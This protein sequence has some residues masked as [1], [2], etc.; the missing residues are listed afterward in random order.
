M[1]QISCDCITSDIS[2]HFPSPPN[3]LLYRGSI[4]GRNW[5]QIFFFS[6]YL[7]DLKAVLHF[8]VFIWVEKKYYNMN[9]L[10]ALRD[11]LGSLSRPASIFRFKSPIRESRNF[12]SDMPD[13][14]GIAA[15]ILRRPGLNLK[16]F[17][18]CYSQS[19]PPADLPPPP[20]HPMVV[21]DWP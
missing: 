2:S 16:N 9:G 5:D 4:L 11:R 12:F 10:E 6:Y 21:L 15:G 13:Q 1:F 17:A 7:L 19:P 3:L 14:G 18:K 20:T 8:K